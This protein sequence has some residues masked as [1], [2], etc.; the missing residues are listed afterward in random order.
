M[1]KAAASL[2]MFVFWLSLL[3]QAQA[4]TLIWKAPLVYYHDLKG[5]CVYESVPISTEGRVE[6]VSVNWVATGAVR[7]A[8][9]ANNGLDYIPVINGVPLEKGLLSGNQLRYKALLDEEGQLHKVIFSYTDTSGAKYTFGQPQLTNFRFRKSIDIA[10]SPE[11]DL[12][13]YQFKINIG[14][15][16]SA[17]DYDLHCE[18]RAGEKFV[19]I[20]FTAA[21]GETPLAF[22]RESIDQDKKS[23]AFWVKIPQLP[24]GENPLRIYLY[25]GNT[26]AQDLSSPEE[27]FDFFDDFDSAGLNLKKWELHNELNA[28]AAIENSQ[29]KLKNSGIL[30]RNF[31]FKDGIIEF[32]AKA[33]A[34]GGIKGIVRNKKE[35][36]LA[37]LTGEAVYSSGVR[38]AEHSIA[39][40]N[41]VRANI[42]NPILPGIFYVYRIIAEGQN[43]IFERYNEKFSQK[44]TELAFSDTKGILQ[45]YIGLKGES[46]LMNHGPVYLDW[47]RVRQYAKALPR[48]LASGKE[49]TVN[50]AK[51]FGVKLNER[52]ELALEDSLQ[53]G[54]YES[55]AIIT[56]FNI[57]I[58]IPESA[59]PLSIS[60]DGSQSYIKNMRNRQYHYASYGDFAAGNNLKF[61]I[62]FSAASGAKTLDKISLQYYPGIITLI[63]PNGAEEWP[64]GSVQNILWAAQE[65]E[66]TYPLKLEYSP[67]KGRT[68]K[69]IV[70]ETPNTG[71]FLWK[72]PQEEQ[73]QEALVKIFD[74]RA[75]QISDISDKIFSI[76]SK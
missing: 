4:E 72:I 53:H 7:M 31:K 28:E 57:R 75:P 63:A 35:D 10:G 60:T 25:Y 70:N 30:S 46:I 3:S 54:R 62:E 5:P 2:F 49:E 39:V 45:G 43:L 22:Y 38:G 71:I 73:S 37:S 18:G 24:K 9:S 59:L 1:K 17:R 34:F 12:F 55:G 66:A 58:I 76:I 27:V 32:K 29:L 15:S 33:D 8:V 11:A 51:F 6:S 26:Q 64:V 36:F 19:D 20:R 48:V 41:V 47:V 61:Q 42:N 74:S 52:G 67:D 68:Y 23:A 65:Y 13:N 21:D 40:D 14:R 56:D 44:Q 50:L 69:T 16:K